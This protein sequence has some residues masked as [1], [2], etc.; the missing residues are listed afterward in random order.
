M[1][2]L[3]QMIYF[4]FIKYISINYK[5]I[6]LFFRYLS[7]WW[8]TIKMCIYV[9]NTRETWWTELVG[10]VKSR[11]GKNNVESSLIISIYSYFLSKD[12]LLLFMLF[13][14][15]LIKIR[16]HACSIVYLNMKN[17]SISVLVS[18]GN[19]LFFHNRQFLKDYFCQTQEQRLLVWPKRMICSLHLWQEN[20]KFSDICISVTRGNRSFS[21]R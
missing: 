8:Q 18:T 9:R 21:L 4:F 7:I 6:K 13:T 5:P 2:F 1:Y 14:Y 15:V 10:N 17:T 20:P 19:F 12:I 3:I 16:I 11:T